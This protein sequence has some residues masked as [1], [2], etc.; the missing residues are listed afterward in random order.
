MNLSIIIPV[1]IGFGKDVIEF[2]KYIHYLSDQMTHYEYEIIISNESDDEVFDYINN[3]M[4]NRTK[5]K[6]IMPD[7]TYRTGAND[8]LNGIYA[9]LEYCTYEK[10][11][12]I[13]DH[14]RVSKNTLEQL[15]PFYEIYDCFKMMPKFD[16][17]PVSALLD[18]CGMY[19]INIL[20]PKKQYCGHLCF[21]KTHITKFGFPSRDSL[22]DE[23]AIETHLKKNK[24]S[25]GYLKNVAL[26]A[27][28]NI[29]TKRFWEQ[30][31][32]YAYEN[33]ALPIRFAIYL[34]ILPI[35]ISLLIMNPLLA[36]CF[37]ISLSMAVLLLA[38]IGQMIYGKKNVPRFSFLL[39][40]IWFWF[41]PFTSWIA[42][43]KYFSG[44]VM[45]G[46]R[47]IKKALVKSKWEKIKDKE[48]I[49]GES[50]DTERESVLK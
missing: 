33:M 4:K 46:G 43:V 21:N 3:E 48:L 30:R 45:F 19:I 16:K 38:F 8:K 36:V 20:D 47:K 6:H 12:L 42:I 18:L 26:E 44:G 41:Y 31:I 7:P 22:F 24:C 1:K 28:Q 10:I 35:L 14:Y 25:T 17:F 27:V 29:S 49:Y 50:I 34:S 23:L 37:A 15:I 5:V 9:A 13:D 39:S 40:P 11:L 32:R 2:V